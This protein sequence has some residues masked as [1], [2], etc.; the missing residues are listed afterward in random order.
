[1]GEAYLNRFG[2][3]TRTMRSRAGF[4]LIELLVIVAIM[5]SM[6]TVGVVSLASSRGTSRIYGAGRDVMAI[7]RRARSFAIITQQ[8]IKIEYSNLKVDDEN[9]VSVQ[10]KNDKGDTPRFFASHKTS[11]RVYTLGGEVAFEPETD[12]EGASGG[13]SIEDNLS[14]D[15]LSEEIMKGLRIKVEDDSERALRSSEGPEATSKIS[16]FSTVDGMTKVVET[17]SVET[18][19]EAEEDESAEISTAIVSEI[20]RVSPPHRI[21]IYNDG[22]DPESGICISVDEFGEPKCEEIDR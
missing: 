15:S 12:D 17:K 5:A 9:C 13:E 21:W 1:M 2:L 6:I 19:E 11:E 8:P 18:K 4:T 3:L 16:I 22:A 20:G 14:P 10:L 7:I